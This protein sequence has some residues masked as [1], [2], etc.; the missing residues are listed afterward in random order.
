VYIIGC[1]G[2]REGF[3]YNV[4]IG[5]IIEMFIDINVCRHIR[6]CFHNMW[7]GGN[8]LFTLCCGKDVVARVIGD[9]LGGKLLYS[10]H[11]ICR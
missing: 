11:W 8:C 3:G 1:V 6:G 10:F 9:G 5:Y 2:I 4:P 7:K